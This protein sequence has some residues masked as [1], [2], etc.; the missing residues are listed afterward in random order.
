MVLL[1][2]VLFAL[3]CVHTVFKLNNKSVWDLICKEKIFEIGQKRGVSQL[4][5]CFD[6]C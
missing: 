5:Q 1:N 2:V 4:K 6:A 3:P